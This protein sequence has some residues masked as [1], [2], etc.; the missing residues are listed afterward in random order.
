MSAFSE[1]ATIYR[2]SKKKHDINWFTEWIARPPAAAVVYAL[3][4]TRITPNQVTFM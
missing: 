3:R 4:N 1:I 2:S